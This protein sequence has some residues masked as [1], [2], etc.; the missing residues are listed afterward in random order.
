MGY[1]ENLRKRIIS[2]GVKNLKEFG[3]HYV[4]EENILTDKVY[5]KFFKNMLIENKGHS[6]MIDETIDKISKEIPNE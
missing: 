2:N 3:Y 6:K 5:S 4:N 1:L